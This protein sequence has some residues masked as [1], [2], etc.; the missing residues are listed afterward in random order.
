[1]RELDVVVAGEMELG[2]KKT[3]LRGNFC[4]SYGR[5]R[6]ICFLVLDDGLFVD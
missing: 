5:I 4:P 3:E 1:M 6:C 2:A